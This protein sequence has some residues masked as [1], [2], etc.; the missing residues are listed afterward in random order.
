MYTNNNIFKDLKPLFLIFMYILSFI[1]IDL[2]LSLPCAINGFNDSGYS[3]P[4]VPLVYNHTLLSSLL[5]IIIFILCFIIQQEYSYRSSYI[6]IIFFILFLIPILFFFDLADRDYS[7]VA[8]YMLR[9]YAFFLMLFFIF[10]QK[11]MFLRGAF[12]A[13]LLLLPHFFDIYF[14]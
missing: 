10:K 6:Y 12:N 13:M 3:K 9:L 14:F 8:I 1:L 4:I 7:L 2:S 5:I 11:S